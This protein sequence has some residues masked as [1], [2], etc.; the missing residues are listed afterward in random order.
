VSALAELLPSLN[1]ASPFPFGLNTR[2]CL[3]LD[4]SR[5]NR[6]LAGVD[7]ADTPRFAEWIADAI[8]HHGAD[9]AAGGYGEDRALYEMSPHFRD[10]DGSTRTLHLGLDLWLAAATPVHAVLDGLV[11]STADNA[12]FGDYGPTIVLEHRCVGQS[13]HTLYG[14]LSRASLTEM[15]VGDRVRAGERIGWLGA[16]DENLG[17]PAHLHLQVVRDMEGRRGDYPGVCLRSEGATWLQRCPDPNL[18][19]RIAALNAVR[20]RV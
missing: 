6:S 13:F 4:L 16:P 7:A 17:W 18:L 14:H 5:G 20:D 11:H 15:R 8:A 10:A 19:L 9:Y 2:R 1:A 12:Q 3:R